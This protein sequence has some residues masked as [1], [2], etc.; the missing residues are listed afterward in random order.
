MED[1]RNLSKRKRRN[2]KKVKKAMI[3]KIECP[4]SKTRATKQFYK[5]K[6]TMGKS[7]EDYAAKLKK[8]ARKASKNSE[9]DLIGTFTHFNWHEGLSH[10]IGKTIAAIRFKTWKEV[11]AAAI[12]IETMN[13]EESKEE[14]IASIDRE[15][16]RCFKCN[17]F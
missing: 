3:S 17:G 2:Y 1:W 7:V 15:N 8:L 10:S 12:K 13:L 14:R 16:S 6:Q 5:L 4:D 9:K 11:T